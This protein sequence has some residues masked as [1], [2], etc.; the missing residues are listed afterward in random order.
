MAGPAAFC[1]RCG[2]ARA[3]AFRFCRGCGLDLDAQAAPASAPQS[4]PAWTPPAP[5]P[6]P[7]A[8]ADAATYRLLT[9]LAWLACAL[10]TGWLGLVQ[11]GNVGTILDSGSLAALGGWNLAMAAL[12]VFGAVRL[13]RSERRGS[14]RTSSV[15]AVV[16]VL[17]QGVQVVGGATHF[18]FVGATVCAAGAGVLAW[19]TYQALP[20]DG[21]AA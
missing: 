20:P 6:A 4:A 17:L 18:A 15:W 21:R 14:F 11:L 5:A 12:V 13:Q 8:G 9:M 16:I 3:G 7:A 2:A 19:L 1:P 10:F